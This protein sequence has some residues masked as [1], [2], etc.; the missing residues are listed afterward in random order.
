MSR[1]GFGQQPVDIEPA[2]ADLQRAGRDADLEG[3]GGGRRDRGA[4]E[5][6]AGQ[7]A[8]AAIEDLVQL[9]ESASSRTRALLELHAGIVEQRIEADSR[10]IGTHDRSSD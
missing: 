1:H 6:V 10:K 9:V 7:G 5:H 3:V 4:P 8:Q 2:L